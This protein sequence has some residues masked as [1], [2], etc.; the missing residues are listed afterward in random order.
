MLW[1]LNLYTISLAK[2]WVESER[3][4]GS[5]FYIEVPNMTEA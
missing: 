5:T 2:I 1:Q 3:G 4:K